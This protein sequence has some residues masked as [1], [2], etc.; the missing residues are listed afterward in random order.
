M[1]RKK[2]TAKQILINLF[3]IMTLYGKVGVNKRELNPE[4]A[5]MTDFGWHKLYRFFIKPRLEV[6]QFFYKLPRYAWRQCSLIFSSRESI[7]FHHDE[8]YV[9]T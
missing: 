7:M 1:K 9:P 3:L 6:V 4:K 8:I 2:E 5:I